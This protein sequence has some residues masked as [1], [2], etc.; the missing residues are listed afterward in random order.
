MPNPMTL[1]LYLN[2][3]PPELKALIMSV[4][5]ACQTIAKAVN[6]SAIRGN[7]G[8]LESENVQ[9]EVQKKLDV[10]A[11]EIMIDHLLEGGLVAALASEEMDT[12]L[13]PKTKRGPYLVAFDPI[14]GSSNIDVNGIVGTIFS[15][16]PVPDEASAREIIEADFLQSGRHQLAAGYTTYGPQTMLILTFGV[17]VSGFTLESDTG[18]W[19]LTHS[20]IVLPPKTQEFSINMSNARHWALPIKTYIDECMAGKEGPRGVNFNMRWMASMVG[21][22]HRILLRGGIFLYP[23]DKRQGMGSGKLRI[24]YEANPMS[25]IIKAAGGLAIHEG[26]EI[27]DIVP[28]A[29]HQRTGVI[30]G[31]RDEVDRLSQSL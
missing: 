8:A 28:T 21:D 14:D 19:I 26:G 30:L 9:G 29:L 13:V 22:V 20:D 6:T 25:M 18:E 10:I 31:S 17:T 15:I 16:L 2:E 4:S 5:T 24:L 12:I 1:D 11:D 23:T 27:L 7:L 3:R